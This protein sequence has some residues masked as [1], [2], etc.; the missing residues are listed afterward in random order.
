VRKRHEK[1][2]YVEYLARD[3][4]ATKA[5]FTTAFGRSFTDFGPSY[6][7]FL[8]Q[9]IDGGFYQSDAMSSTAKG[10]ALIVLYS[11]HLEETL[12][13]V[14]AAG[15][16]VIKPIFPFPGGRRFHLRN[17]AA[18]SSR[19]GL[20]PHRNKHPLRRSAAHSFAR[21]RRAL[22][23]TGDPHMQGH[24]DGDGNT[25]SQQKNGEEGVEDLA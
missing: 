16:R 15:G 3:L 8:N 13:K 18:T 20:L 25:A 7:A 23:L 5:F 22:E 10:A 6:T 11:D 14:E 1:F 24:D 2:D 4:E 17:P 21:S 19:S 12:A 9:G